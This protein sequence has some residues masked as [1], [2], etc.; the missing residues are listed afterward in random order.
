MKLTIILEMKTK[1]KFLI[2]SLFFMILTVKVFSYSVV[3][4]YHKVGYSED[5]IYTMLPEMLEEQVKLIKKLGITL[6]NVDFFTN[7]L[8]SENV[9]SV[10]FD[11][12]R[13]IND[14]ILSF[15]ENEKV[16]ITLFINPSTIGGKGFFSWKEIK[17]LSDSDFV[18]IGSHSYSHL[19]EK[20]LKRETL[21]NQVVNSRN[22]IE[23]MIGKRVFAFAY[24]FGIADSEARN[25]VS[26]TYKVGF[27]VSEENIKK[28][29]DENY[30]RLPRYVIHSYY[31]LGKFLEIVD[32]VF[33]KSKID[34]KI[35]DLK[36]EVG[37]GRLYKFSVD[38][39]ESSILVVPSL[40]V[41]AAW[42]IPEINALREFNADVWVFENEIFNFPFYKYEILY[43]KLKYLSLEGSSRL[44]REA[45]EIIIS[46]SKKTTIIAWGDG[47]D[48]TLY[49]LSE[50]PK[51]Q[52]YISKLVLINPSMSGKLSERV[53]ENNINVYKT[54]M[55]SGKYEL[56]KFKNLLKIFN[57]LH[58]AYLK[59]YEKS[60]FYK[61]MKNLEAFRYEISKHID[62]KTLIKDEEMLNVIKQVEYSP[63]S[64]SS[65]INPTEYFLGINNW[66]YENLKSVPPKI[67][68]PTLII[69]NDYY[70]DS[71]ENVRKLIPSAVIKRVDLSTLDIILND[72]M[73]RN[74]F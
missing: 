18:I 58:I 10:T 27:E 53:L 24:P 26:K 68:V 46:K 40:F 20:N 48:L 63:L 71:T 29:D 3:L 4:C 34:H 17:R 54:L 6:K 22:Y 70:S 21:I 52:K 73:V 12:G 28:V 23:R 50:N 33:D 31:T 55:S 42:F 9:V 11:D 66:W 19:F 32:G 2:I 59:P 13:R 5:D 36:G 39:P 72:D 57:L 25:L 56:K 8:P 44:L 7:F 67:E 61:G 30:Y 69:Y 37:E 45:L 14:K 41:G 43:Q 49:T 38:S 64:A 51:Y 15:F 65:L 62:Y 16:P 35:Y 1:V 74:I 47:I 60:P